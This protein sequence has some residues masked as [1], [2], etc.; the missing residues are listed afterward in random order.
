MV[1]KAAKAPAKKS[2]PAA[3]AKKA[4][5][6]PKADQDA[7]KKPRAPKGQGKAASKE[8]QA[9]A[10]PAAAAAEAAKPVAA[11]QA[12]DQSN[13]APGANSAS[14]LTPP[15]VLTEKAQ[16]LSGNHTRFYDVKPGGLYKGPI[17]GVADGMALQRIGESNTYIMHS[18]ER[19]PP[20]IQ[21]LAKLG[22][23]TAPVGVAYNR[24]GQANV[25][26]LEAQT[27]ARTQSQAAPAQA[28]QGKYSESLS[29][30]RAYVKKDHGPNVQLFAAKT[31]QNTYSGTIATITSH[32]V[33]QRVSETSFVLHDRA[34]LQGD[35]HK[36][37]DVKIAYQNGKGISTLRGHQQEQ[38]P[39]QPAN[40]Q[41]DAQEQP[42]SDAKYQALTKFSERIQDITEDGKIYDAKTGGAKYDGPVHST[43]DHYILQQVRDSKSF[44]IHEVKDLTKDGLAILRQAN[45]KG[46]NADLP[47][48]APVTFAYD[49]GKLSVTHHEGPY[50]ALKAPAPAAPAKAPTQAKQEPAMSR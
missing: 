23:G 12:P 3:E 7:P 6:T 22:V 29:V 4:D 20:E 35:Y 9:P 49:H 48:T 14:A 13:E 37:N 33:A 1:T 31:Q 19:M 5:K 42:I 18:A 26:T 8:S 25:Y 10:A 40:A 43:T 44:V 46:N 39:S 17:V 21:G 28:N 50:K 27:Q 41:S 45:F 38:R 24:E 34:N 32:H 30:A 15:T 47:G 16:A 11:P 2:A 36:G